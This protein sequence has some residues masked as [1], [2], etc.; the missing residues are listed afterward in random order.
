M[1][2]HTHDTQTIPKEDQAEPANTELAQRVEKQKKIVA[3]LEDTYK[4]NPSDESELRLKR[5][6]DAL[7]HLQLVQKGNPGERAEAK[8]N[9]AAKAALSRAI[10]PVEE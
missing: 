4:K 6:R 10:Q 5:E 1:A 9:Y 8:A 3:E 2:E 7:R